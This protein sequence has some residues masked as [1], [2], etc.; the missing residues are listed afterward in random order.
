MLDEKG[1]IFR[2][3]KKKKKKKDESKDYCIFCEKEVEN[4]H[5]AIE[6]DKCK[7]W[8]HIRCDKVMNGWKYNRIKKGIELFQ[9]SCKKCI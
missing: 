9:W 4:E 8:Q 2:K 3:N 5:K 6:C 1:L 7:K